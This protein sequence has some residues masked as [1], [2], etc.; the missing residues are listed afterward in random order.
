MNDNTPIINS[1]CTIY[2]PEGLEI[3]CCDRC[4]CDISIPDH[5]H[6]LCTVCEEVAQ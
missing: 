5:P 2:E 3:G 1:N 6:G 4:D